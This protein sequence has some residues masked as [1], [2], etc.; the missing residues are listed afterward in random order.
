MKE[1]I[2]AKCEG[3]MIKIL[4]HET[5]VDD[6]GEDEKNVDLFS[7]EDE[8]LAEDADVK[9]KVKEGTAASPGKKSRKKLL[10][11]SYEPDK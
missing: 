4:D 5:V 10:L 6:A 11:S 9:P 1:A 3:L 7:E 8:L 2:D